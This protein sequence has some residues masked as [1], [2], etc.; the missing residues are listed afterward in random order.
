MNRNKLVQLATA[1]KETRLFHYCYA[2]VTSEAVELTIAVYGMKNGITTS[3]PFFRKTLD[4]FSGHG[5]TVVDPSADPLVIEAVERHYHD[6]C[7][8]REALEALQDYIA[9]ASD[10]L[11][12]DP[13]HGQV[14][15]GAD[16]EALRVGGNEWVLPGESEYAIGQDRFAL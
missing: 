14:T 4:L 1:C 8:K 13:L 15:F 5:H 2:K 10:R 7:F 3:A 16:L 12:V 9:G 6:V 11:P